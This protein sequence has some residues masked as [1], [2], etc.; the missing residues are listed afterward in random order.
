M[1]WQYNPYAIPSFVSALVAAGLIVVAWRRRAASAAKPFA[2]FMAAILV[3]AGFNGLLLITPDIPT[4]LLLI[5]AL[6]FGVVTVPVGWLAFAI[7]YT[8]RETWLSRRN[9]ALLFIHPVLTWII[10]WTNDAHHL[11]WSFKGV[12]LARP[13]VPSV[14]L[15]NGLWFWS[16]VAYNYALVLVG[17]TLFIVDIIRSPQVYRQRAVL[18]IS[19]AFVPWVASVMYVFKLGPVPFLDLTPIAFTLS[20]V[21]FAFAI[22]RYRMLD[23]VPIAREAVLQSMADAVF[24][25]DARNRVVDLNPAAQHLLN[26]PTGDVIGR[27]AA[28]IL[29]S[30]SDLMEN[31]RDVM[32]GQSEITLGSG[33]AQRTYEMRI[34][35]VAG[36]GS[37]MGRLVVLHDI[38]AHKLSEREILKRSKELAALNRIVAQITSVFDVESR[39]QTT[40]REMVELFKATNCGI[41]LLD[42]HQTQLMVIASH[43]ATPDFP[44][45]VGVNIPVV[46]NPSAEQAINT[47]KTFVVADAQ[48]NPKTAPI[49]DTMRTLNIHSLMVVP[50]VTG[51]LVMGTAG[52]VT[53]DPNRK[54]TP[55]EVTLAE[56][57][58]GQ[59]ASAIANARL[60]EQTQAALVERQRAQ[61]ELLKAKEAAEDANRAKSAFLA[62]MSHELRTPL[63]AIIG[64]SEMLAEEAPEMEAEQLI[65][66]LQKIR[67]SGKHLLGLINDVLD[68]SKIEAGRMDLY[69]EEFEVAHL[70]EDVVATVEPLAQKSNVV[71]SVR[72]PDDLGLMF[73]DITKVRQSLINILTNAAKFAAGAAV[74]FSIE[75]RDDWFTFIIADS[76]IGITP[77]QLGRLFQPFTQADTSTTRRY[78]GT[79]LGLAISQRFCKMMGGE[80]VV[81]SA[82]GAGSTFTVRLPARVEDT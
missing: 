48:H 27:Q 40:A 54:F 46:G 66:D 42:D 37:H 17:T 32:E 52:I 82:L 39:L 64:Y 71:L 19:G 14:D 53:T 38:T 63:N 4:Q 56:T 6:Y 13:F 62:N 81:E 31:Y 22:F 65:A 61:A 29:T 60:L 80:I 3:W 15:D 20:G 9:L 43:S 25:L 44:S 70:I 51:G 50:L 35:L 77:E 75:R 33:E 41:A 72:Q 26:R 11:M 8:D 21:A 55:D 24:V 45:T 58:A 47:G 74:D 12:D 59:I 49:H 18:L 23:I 67:N 34:S 79:G 2:F 30:R 76:G 5:K 78:G 69:L 7:H 16:V 36:R 73:A 28:N 68:I 1:N 10:I 57:I